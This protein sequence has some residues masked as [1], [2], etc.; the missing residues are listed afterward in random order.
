MPLRA[1]YER[2]TLQTE[3]SLVPTFA[4]IPDRIFPPPVG[5][6]ITPQGIEV[7]G[8]AAPYPTIGRCNI[9]VLHRVGMDIVQRSIVMPLGA[10]KPV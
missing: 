2:G 8:K 10:D 5:Q 7:K 9:P 4:I 6:A 3:N 1:H